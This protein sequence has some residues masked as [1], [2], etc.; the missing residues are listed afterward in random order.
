MG[1]RAHGRLR[2]RLLALLGMTVG[3]AAM[4]VGGTSA[5]ASSDVAGSSGAAASPGAAASTSVLAEGEDADVDDFD[6]ES[7]HVD[8]TLGRAEDG[9]S[10][11]TV[12]ETFVAVFP[13]SD[14]NH[15]MKRGIP[16]AFDDQPHW[17]RLV[18]IT[19][20]NGDE[21]PQET[22]TDD[23]EYVMI[24]RA[25]DYLHGRQTFTFT[26]ELENVTREFLSDATNDFYWDVTPPYRQ[27][28]IG[29]FS[30]TVHVPEDLV[31][32]LN[33]NS[34]CYWGPYGDE[35]R[36]DITHDDEDGGVV[37]EAEVADLGL[38]DV[39][40]A[41]GFDQGTFA[42]FDPSPLKS[43]FAIAQLVL[44]APLGAVLGWCI[45]QR[46]RKL[47]DEPGRPTVIVEYA[48]P[49]LISAMEA[50]AFLN[51]A[52]KG[53]A[54]EILAQAVDGS[55][56][57]VEEEGK[58]RSRPTFS[59][60]LIDMS[61]VSGTAKR[62]LNAMFG[63]SNAKPG[64]RFTF[65]G[66][67][68]AKSRKLAKVVASAMKQQKRYRRQV[69]RA[70][71]VGPLI[72]LTVAAVL[73]FA[74]GIVSLL[75]WVD[76]MLPL[77]LIL[78]AVVGGIAGALVLARSPLNAKGAELRD[79]LAGVKLFIRLAEADRIRM[80]QSPEGAERVP[81]DTDDPRE[82][83]RLYESL[84]PYAVIFGLE[85]KWAEHLAFYYPT[86]NSPNWYVGSGAFS[87]ATFSQGVSSISVASAAATSS[88]S[89]VSGSGGGG[90]VGG[91]GGGGSAGGL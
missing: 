55:V 58:R 81:V 68:N 33:G 90:S 22:D 25:D 23:D 56:R 51:R 16:E 19:D 78:A 34:E 70:V 27:Q 85:K 71:R 32:E 88:S 66:K 61:D 89:G 14:Q 48:P 28:P 67:R 41:V 86:D 69:P 76:P 7:L 46:R 54:A 5:A 18:S 44:V 65:D 83:L 79:H 60:E 73:V 91:G 1:R 31:D 40:I 82:M 45:M 20:E 36:C 17:P 59:A 62:V 2:A 64:A 3:V 35:T 80:L 75:Q 53:V 12:V 50:A 11:L 42:M 74:L 24:S 63:G 30:V 77:L 39:T 57:L 4:T 84:L 29:D 15:G 10:T 47:R 37:F 6:Y 13:D 49:R 52:N 8:Y 21:R 9:T 43:P 26:Y 38:E 87:A 72:V